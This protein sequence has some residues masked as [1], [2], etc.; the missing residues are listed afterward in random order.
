MEESLPKSLEDEFANVVSLKRVFCSD[1]SDSLNPSKSSHGNA[2]YPTSFG[3]CAP[4]SSLVQ[5][6]RQLLI[7]RAL[8]TSFSPLVRRPSW[9]L[10]PFAD[11]NQSHR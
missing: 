6:H 2:P 7:T 10:G 4:E 3:P 11:D 8:A 9:R 5:S 1:V